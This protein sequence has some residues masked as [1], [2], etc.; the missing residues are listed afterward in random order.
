MG[1]NR[2]VWCLP[3]PMVTGTWMKGCADLLT[4]APIGSDPISGFIAFLML[5][6][7][8]LILPFW[9]VELALEL[10]LWPFFVAGRA[11]ARVVG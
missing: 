11:V 10:V 4:S 6:P 7:M 2:S 1:A 9:L 5:V 8:L 3:W